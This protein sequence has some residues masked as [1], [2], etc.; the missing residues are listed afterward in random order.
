MKRSLSLAVLALSAMLPVGLTSAMFKAISTHM[1]ASNG[2]SLDEINYL[3]IG[4]T[5]AQIVT[6]LFTPLIM[7]RFRPNSVLCRTLVLAALSHLVLANTIQMPGIHGGVWLVLGVCASLIMVSVNLLVLDGCNYREMTLIT[8][9]ILLCSTL[10]PMGVYPWLLSWLADT[11]EWQLL[12]YLLAGILLIARFQADFIADV[13]PFDSAKK[14]HPLPYLIMASG[15]TLA[16]FLLMRGSYY[17]WFDHTFFQQATLVVAVLALGAMAL[18]KAAQRTGHT[19]NHKVLTNLH[20]NVFMYNGFLAGFAVTASGAL[21][22]NFLSHVMHYSHEN[23]G[24]IQLPSFLAMCVGM[25]ISV[26]AA[27]Q[28]RFPSDMITPIGVVLMIISIVMFSHLPS[29]VGPEALL[30]PL[31][32]R[33]L[34]VGLLN[35]SVTIAMLAHFKPEQRPE[36]ISVFYICRT[37]GGLIGSAIFARIMQVTSSES[38]TELSRTLDHG[39][40]TIEQYT[41]AV[42]RAV[43]TQ[44]FLPSGQLNAGQLSQTLQLEVSTLSLNNTFLFFVLAVLLMAPVILI[45]KKMVKKQK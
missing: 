1:A 34:G 12:S 31:C 9:L 24:L 32:L 42:Q 8:A 27:N 41:Q 29:Y 6:L 19:I 18:M 14:S 36:G 11:I 30:F 39:S 43:L 28:N 44:G 2:L 40:Q 15:I 16:V 22:A 45:G 25:L 20:N 33:G 5:I 35:V 3:N 38:M 13:A 4:F 10:L 21:V 23:A 37:F 26:A 7:R 17:N